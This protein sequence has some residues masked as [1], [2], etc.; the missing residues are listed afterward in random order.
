MR[1]KGYKWFFEQFPQSE[2]TLKHDVK[3][4]YQFKCSFQ[5]LYV[6]QR[7]FSKSE[8]QGSLFSTFVF[9]ALSAITSRSI[10][11]TANAIIPFFFMAE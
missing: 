2:K 8:E 7:L 11:V 9:K 3:A 5:N 6:M 1:N 10:H 4:L